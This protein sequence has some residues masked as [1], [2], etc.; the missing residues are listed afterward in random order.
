MRALI[1]VAVLCLATPALAADKTR[2]A[3]TLD[4]VTGLPVVSMQ[5][6]RQGETANFVVYACF[7]GRTATN[8]I[9]FLDDPCAV[10]DA[11][12]PISNTSLNPCRLKVL[13]ANGFN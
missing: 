3:A 9:V 7:V 12:M 2:P 13:A 1:A 6:T 11:T 5:V 4:D 8:Q 10:C